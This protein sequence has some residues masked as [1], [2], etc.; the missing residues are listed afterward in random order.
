[1]RDLRCHFCGK[2]HA[3]VPSTIAF[4]RPVH[5]FRVPEAERPTRCLENDDYCIIDREEFLIPGVIL[6]PIRDGVGEFEWGAWALVSS[7]VFEFAYTHRGDDCTNEPPFTGRLSI[8]PPGYD[9]LYLEPVVIQLR[10]ASLRPTFTLANTSDHRMAHEQRNGITV[11]DW[12]RIVATTMP[13]L[14]GAA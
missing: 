11:A 9:G 3:D 6:I 12:H 7:H 1:V 13:W 10:T 2:Q 8:E 5:Y 14:F 4:R